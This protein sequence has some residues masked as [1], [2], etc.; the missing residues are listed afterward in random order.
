MPSSKEFLRK[1][2]DQLSDLEEMTSRQMMGEYLLY[3]KGKLFGGI[4]DDRL[5]LKPF[6][7]FM[8]HLDNPR[9]QKPYEGAKEMI[10]IE[11]YDN[12]SLL[13]ATIR[14]LEEDK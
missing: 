3:Y 8:S 12:K 14:L 6:P 7:I 1:I 5:L 13:T 9:F 10:L 4:Y 2:L 11:D